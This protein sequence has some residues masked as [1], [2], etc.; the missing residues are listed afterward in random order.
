MIK[1]DNE[2]NSLHDNSHKFLM[3]FSF[4]ICSKAVAHSFLLSLYFENDKEWLSLLLVAINE[5]LGK[6]IDVYS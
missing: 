1:W 6:L 5:K 4:L 2:L 3:S